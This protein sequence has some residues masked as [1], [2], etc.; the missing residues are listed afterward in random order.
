ML[1]C[2]KCNNVA[3]MD[4]PTDLCDYHWA[5]WFWIEDEPNPTPTHWKYLD[6]CLD[7]ME[8][9]YGTVQRKPL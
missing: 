2:R 5:Y 8:A 3:T 4:S 1:K 9:K 7:E 6:Q